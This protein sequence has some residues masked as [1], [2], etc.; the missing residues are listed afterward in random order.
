MKGTVVSTWIKTCRKQYSD[1]VVN[2]ALE[3]V[4]FKSNKTFSPLE[5]VDDTVVVKLFSS[6]ASAV[7]SDEA[8]LWR[9]IGKDNIKTFSKDYP[10]FFNHD[11]LYHFLK[12]MD[13][14]H[15]IVMKRIKGAKPP[16]LELEPISSREAVFTYRSK[17]GMYEYFQGLLEGA[18][19][20][21][22]EKIDIVQLD[23][24]E[25]ELK[26]KIIFEK[27]IQY[28]KSFFMNKL[29]SF[30][31]IKDV[32]IKIALLSA[33][34]VPLSSIVLQMFIDFSQSEVIGTVVLLV[35]SF[36]SV[37]A[38]SKILYRPYKRVIEEIVNFSKR[39]YSVL[40]KMETR[41]QF[42]EI[43]NVIN[44][45]KEN[46]RKDFV[47]FKGLVDEMN[48]FSN[49]ISQIAINMNTTSDEI[50]DVVE[51]LAT[52]AAS[53]AEET[54]SSIYTLNE[55][56][57]QVNQI[58]GEE[59]SNKGELEKSVGKI[60]NSY[61]EVELT[62]SEIDKLL[63]SFKQ[64]QENGVRLKTKAQKITEIVSIVS[65]ISGQTNLLA[66]NA[67]IE[68]A[69]AGELGKGFAVVADEVRNLS[70]ETSDAVEKIKNNLNEFVL[71]IEK[72]VEDVDG[73]Y[74]VLVNENDSLAKAVESSNTANHNISSVANKM[75]ETSKRLENEANA[76][77]NVFQ[78]MES[79]A[80]IAEE[81]SASAQQVSANV[82]DYTDQIK[83]IT[84]SI[85]SFKEITEDFKKEI[86]QYQL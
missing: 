53:Q 79:L 76:I 3:S 62:A 36:L 54:E 65:A 71:E 41:D 64:V 23:K 18:A 52:A 68:A 13:N 85:T 75:I 81:N 40:T 14:V 72:L 58:A 37:Y 34:L 70:E 77:S 10:G 11:S 44:V 86:E 1:Q 38:S 12:S 50:S 33:I 17:R 69:R 51:Q 35:I 73:Q 22:N 21:F 2:K 57:N 4:G 39:D 61:K 7:N 82:T 19:E 28:K 24:N 29:M 30:G 9:N 56:V 60:E 67:S 31:F 74:T 84:D 63:N 26:L 25:G 42:E 5:D 45:Y 49:S 55:N 66:L 27:D 48:T 47:G 83:N 16:K 32:H 8:K 20:F 46:I 43:F 15:S 6:I 80:A 78:N 59:H